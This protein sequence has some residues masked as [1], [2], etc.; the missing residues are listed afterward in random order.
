MSL[1]GL[2]S[3]VAA[4]KDRHAANISK[5]EMNVPDF[6]SVSDFAVVIYIHM[7]VFMHTK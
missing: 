2:V 7:N 1:L 6:V 5:R 3:K 4:A